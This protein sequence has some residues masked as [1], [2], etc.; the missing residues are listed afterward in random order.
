MPKPELPATSGAETFT[1]YHLDREAGVDYDEAQEFV[2]IAHN[3]EHARP[4]PWPPGRWPEQVFWLDPEHS[5]VTALGS[6]TT[7]GQPRIVVYNIFGG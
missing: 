6:T 7:P 2:V 1:I 3:L 5:T 4:S